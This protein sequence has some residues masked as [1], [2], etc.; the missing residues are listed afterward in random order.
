VYNLRYDSDL[1]D[2]VRKTFGKL[3][4]GLQISR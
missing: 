2:P 4:I 3:M 1:V